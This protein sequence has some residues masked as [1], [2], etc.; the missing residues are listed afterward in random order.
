MSTDVLVAAQAIRPVQMARSQL[1]N[2]CWGIECQKALLIAGAQMGK[3]M[4]RP[5]RSG[6]GTKIT[7][8]EL[9]ATT[10]LT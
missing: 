3:L 9:L 2:R 4:L 7:P 8:R 6:I 5:V 10:F 1:L